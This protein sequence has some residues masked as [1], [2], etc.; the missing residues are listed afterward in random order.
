[1]RAV[2]Q[3]L[4]QSAERGTIDQSLALLMDPRAV[5]AQARFPRC[6]V[7]GCI[8]LLFCEA[9]QNSAE[10]EL[11]RSDRLQWQLGVPV[12]TFRDFSEERD[13]G[14]G[15][16]ARPCGSFERPRIAGVPSPR[17][18]EA[19]RAAAFLGQSDRLPTHGGSEAGCRPEVLLKVLAASSEVADRLPY[20]WPLR[21]DVL[22]GVCPGRCLESEVR[23][24][25][26]RRRSCTGDTAAT[27]WSRKQHEPGDW[28]NAVAPHCLQ[29]APDLR[30]SAPYA[31]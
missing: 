20:R 12:D 22:A 9:A 2:V 11:W 28:A 23:G 3:F 1:M 4:R 7:C 31:A 26:C 18:G 16:G 6:S 15:T 30:A 10:P 27:W 29:A 21:P 17:P 14:G 24:E 8:L 13:N 19:R 25:E 5:K